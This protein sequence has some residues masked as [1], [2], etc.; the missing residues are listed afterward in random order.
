AKLAGVPNIIYTAHGF[1]FH[2]NMS[3]E[4]YKLF[5]TIEKLCAKWCT[6]YIFTQSEEDGNLAINK[7][8]L[9]P[10]KITIIGN[11]VDVNEKFNPTN[12]HKDKIKKYR[13]EF[14]IKENDLVVT[15]IGRLVAEK[16][17]FDLLEA[18]EGI[19]QKDIIL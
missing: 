14:Y 15:F 6:D 5:Y 2:E 4:K 9:P 17:I 8:F 19:K 12:V 16:G 10:G 11:G 13:N 1:Y 18:F 7:N 3:P